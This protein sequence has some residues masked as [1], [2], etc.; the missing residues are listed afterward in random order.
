M[1]FLPLNF[2]LVKSPAL[3]FVVSRVLFSSPVSVYWQEH[4]IGLCNLSGY[5][6]TMLATHMQISPN[7]TLPPPAQF[8][9][10]S[11]S[12]VLQTFI[13]NSDTQTYAPD[14]KVGTREGVFLESLSA[15]KQCI[16]ACVIPH[17]CELR[18]LNNKD[19]NLKQS[20][21]SGDF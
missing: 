6:A 3:E 12:T 11:S 9:P 7:I 17:P 18:P 5:G 20:L 19:C 1:V 21:L 14:T 16:C 15:G 4:L 2:F 13:V 8:I 10:V